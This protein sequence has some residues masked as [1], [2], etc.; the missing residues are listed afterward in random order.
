MGASEAEEFGVGGV[1]LDGMSRANKLTRK[2]FYVDL[3]SLKRARKA[4]RVR[5]DSEA[6]RASLAMVVEMEE[7]WPFLEKTAGKLG[8]KSF[9]PI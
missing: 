9:G 1:E 8:P 3:A 6:V 7:L 5:T 4:L 2:T